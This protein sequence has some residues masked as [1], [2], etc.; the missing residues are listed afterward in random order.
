MLE[1]LTTVPGASW[2]VDDLAEYLRLSRGFDDD[3]ELDGHLETC[4]RSASGAIEARIGKAIFRRRFRQTV[5]EWAGDTRHVFPIAPVVA[6]ETVRITDR[7]GGETLLDPAGYSLVTDIHCPALSSGNLSLPTLGVGQTAEIEFLAGYAE[8]AAGLPADLL[9][10]MLVLAG[11]FF[12]QS[13][14]AE[15]GLPASVA[16]LIEPYRTLRL[17]GACA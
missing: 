14:D 8:N 12:A 13:V 15:T 16:V 11:S 1:E 6:I 3:G 9:Q 4:L 7:S 2:P 10:A 5:T 17:R